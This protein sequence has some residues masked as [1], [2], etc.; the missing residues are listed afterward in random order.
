MSNSN[1]NSGSLYEE[2]DEIALRAMPPR[3]NQLVHHNDEHSNRRS[4]TSLVSSINQPVHRQI[5]VS[6]RLNDYLVP[7]SAEIRHFMRDQNEDI[8]TN[9]TDNDES[10]SNRTKSSYKT[11]NSYIN[12]NANV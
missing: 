10:S 6:D 12:I 7:I 8:N 3:I 9:S 5:G 4:E 2:I 11:K 1:R